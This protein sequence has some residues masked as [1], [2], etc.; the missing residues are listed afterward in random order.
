MARMTLALAL[1]GLVAASTAQA[2]ATGKHSGTIVGVAA[3]G[4]TVT[5]EEMGPWKGPGQAPLRR[6]I[7]LTP[8]TK[9]VLVTRA[10]GA[11]PDGWLGGFT[12]SR[13]SMSDVQRADYVTVSAVKR[14]GRLMA[15]SVEV[16]RPGSAGGS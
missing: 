3:K 4:S 16:V 7:H 2:A 13:L 5:L 8:T 9:I 10:S 1:A 6:V 12:A 14:G 15:V 11:T